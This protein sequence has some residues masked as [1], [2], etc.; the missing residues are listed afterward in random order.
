MGR[1]DAIDAVAALLAEH[2]L[3]TV[4]GPGGGGKTRLAGEVARK[5][6]GRFADG[7]WLV[8]LAGVDADPAAPDRVVAAIAGAIGIRELPAHAAASALTAALAQRQLLL[9]LDNC[10]HL[11]E[12]TAE[13]CGAVLLGADDVR[14]LA[15]SRE[16]LR[17]GGE[18]RYRLGPLTVAPRAEPDGRATAPGEAAELF[19]DRARLADPGF[20][21]DD[22]TGPAVARLVKAL[23][24]M[25]LAIELA[26]ARVESL[27]V[28]GLIDGMDD[29]FEL[30][31]EGDRLAAQRQRSLAATVRWSHELLDPD[32]QRVFRVVSVFPG[33]FTLEGA[34]VVTAAL[35]VP[36]AVT[37]R[38]VPRLVDC[39]M[40]MPPQIGLDGRS[41]YG[42]LET[43]RAYG[44][45]LLAQAGEDQVASG[46]LAT[47][48]ADVALEANTGL[49]TRTWELAGVRHLL[50]ED[51]T[52]SGALAWALE[53]DRDK[54]LRLALSL[55]PCWQI[56]G[57]LLG[58][59]TVL[60]EVAGHA[61][62]AGDMWC[63]VRMALGQAAAQS[64]DL[65]R[66]LEHF[67]AV[68][69]AL[70][71][72]GRPQ[73]L[74]G[75]RLLTACL[76]GRSSA[77][78]Y[79]GRVPEA[80]DDASQSLAMA[81]SADAPTLTALALACLAMA[82]WRT[83]NKDGA[84][85]LVRQARRV[86]D[87]FSGRAYRTL[88]LI[89]AR[90]LAAVGDLATAGQV[91]DGGLASCREAGDLGNMSGLLW[92]RTVI[93]LGAGRLAD[94]VEHVHEQLQVCQRTG[95]RS[96]LIMGL[97]CCGYLCA[98]SGRPAEA[99]TVW[100]AMGAL[101]GSSVLL[102]AALATGRREE[103]LRDAVQSLG[104]ELTR[105]A[106]E[107]GAGMSRAAMAEYALLLT[108]GGPR[109]LPAGAAPA[110]AAIEGTAAGDC[111][112][113]AP[114]SSAG[115]LSPRECELV[116]LVARGLTDTQIA[117]QLFIS[118]RTVSSHL[119]RIRDKTGYR[120]RA[121]LTRLALTLG[122]V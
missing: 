64:M 32:E 93:D 102:F 112:Q 66:A 71:D 51:V 24:G 29:R 119:D 15:T 5:V 116:T 20:V 73:S 89:L 72:P 78:L 121:D 18:S 61:E 25:P 11:I 17:I 4:T 99:V 13:V 6:A 85:E 68:R 77:L 98:V 110:G 75:H 120:R 81:R 37:R 14:V 92:A 49:A 105:A 10:E 76:A 109:G 57:Q 80:L 39:S 38:A 50:A 43:L 22:Q 34:T 86:P 108:T 65:D 44:A 40:L 56:R 83:G 111:G 47:F 67:T 46:A 35:A 107:R 74:G 26:A 118:T 104:P 91:A 9:V 84:I 90:L 27:G 23:D 1:A 60:T 69:D 28:A 54:A 59:V 3:V 82:T 62:P 55:V 33:P 79:L 16:P 36:A 45:G 30:L 117:A 21:L 114:V 41:R 88:S 100:A 122:L 52:L 113:E 70:R 7:A 58:H 101:G 19:A 103:L 106:E 95:M 42:M 87:E 63:T 94:A 115:K 8:S 97:D 31:A 96:S 12:A 48:A 53:H 2:R